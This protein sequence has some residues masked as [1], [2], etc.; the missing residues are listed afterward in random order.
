M[1][2]PPGVPVSFSTLAQRTRVE[3]G[4]R[5]EETADRGAFLVRQLGII[6]PI[7]VGPKAIE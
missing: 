6:R 4:D 3:L 7:G 2:P 1:V 5:G